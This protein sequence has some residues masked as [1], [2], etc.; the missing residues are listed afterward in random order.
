MKH[1]RPT[2]W[3]VALLLALGPGARLAHGEPMFLS[4]QYPQ[5]TS[6]HFSP[7]GGGLLTAYGR[8]LSHVE[9]STSVASDPLTADSPSGEQA[10]LFGALGDQ[11]GGLQLGLELRP[12][13]LQFTF[14]GGDGSRNL[15]MAAEGIA[16]YQSNGWTAYGQ[17]GRH[18]E[19]SDA[20]VGSY[21]HWVGYQSEGGVGVRA[22][23]FM[24]AYGVHFA[25]HTA[26]NRAPMGFDK[27]D[28]IY[29]VEVSRTGERSLVQVAVGP[30]RAESIV[31]D[32]G[33]QAFM[34][35][36]RVQLDLTPRAVLVA[37]GIVRGESDVRSRS[38]A[39]G[40]ALGFAPGSRL[41]TWTQIDAVATTRP[42]RTAWVVV[43][44]T[45]LEV[46]RGVWIKASPQL[47]TDGGRGTGD[48]GRLVIGAALLPRT[49]W[50]VNV[51][52]FRDRNRDFGISTSTL[53]AQLHLFL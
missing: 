40:L 50:N 52:Y 29:G 36:A 15:L 51:S 12:S 1:L 30:G 33:R 3:L 31:D 8:S 22:G 27:D 7:T 46:Y 13:H 9:L 42:S 49:H 20:S 11:L 26:F 44:E 35:S 48:I 32:D 16:A 47:R 17:V 39:A 23:R 5:C 10:F 45:A 2:V 4:K 53:L 37:S 34:T 21:Q 28:Q 43:N 6:C 24:P 41:T 38:G 25:D 19:G 18:V 14:P